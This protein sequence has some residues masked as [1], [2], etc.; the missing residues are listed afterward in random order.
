[1]SVDYVSAWF[2]KAAEFGQRTKAVSAFVATNSI[3]QGQQVSILWPLIKK[4]KHD[5][6]FAY[7]SFT[8][9]NLAS[10]NAGVTVVIVAI[11]AEQIPD[12]R[13]FTVEGKGEVTVRVVPNINAYL[14]PGPDTIVEA[15]RKHISALPELDRGNSL[16]HRFHRS[17]CRLG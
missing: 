11:S 10:H 1:M 17:R 2:L 16:H 3:C 4:L 9:A 15:R 14:V 6:C 5:I 8:W 7:T 12:K 13:L